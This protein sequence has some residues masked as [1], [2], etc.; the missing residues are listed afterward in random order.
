[1]QSSH[2]L[3]ERQLDTAWMLNYVRQLTEQDQRLPRA[4]LLKQLLATAARNC[5]SQLQ[6]LIQQQFCCAALLCK[7]VSSSTQSKPRTD[8]G[9]SRQ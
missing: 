2:E 5:S 1:M 7:Y 6:L 3:R 8:T 4:V 9:C